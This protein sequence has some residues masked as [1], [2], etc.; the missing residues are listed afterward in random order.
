MSPSLNRL[1]DSVPLVSFQTSR[2]CR[3]LCRLPSGRAKK[4]R[5]AEESNKMYRAMKQ[6]KPCLPNHQSIPKSWRV[7]LR[8]MQV[9]PPIPFVSPAY[10]HTT[11]YRVGQTRW[12]T[13]PY[14][15]LLEPFP[16]WRV[17]SAN[18]TW[19]CP[20]SIIPSPGDVCL[21]IFALK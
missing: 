18:R 14:E 2:T 20:F 1:A 3:L 16:E 21:H 15:T 10:P 9:Q 13:F 4:V 19:M 17:N 12:C 8:H 6:E 11:T 7:L 5:I